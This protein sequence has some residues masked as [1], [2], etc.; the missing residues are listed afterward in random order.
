MRKVAFLSIVVII[1]ILGGCSTFNQS[2]K[3][4]TDAAANKNWND[5]IKY[6]EK[7]ILEYP[8]NAAHRL[9][10]TRA[11]SLASYTHV[12]KSRK[13]AAAGKN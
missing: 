6:Y 2:Y 3:L 7:A 13:L 8:S 10:L 11:K 1:L 5:A 9:A 12:F 4:A